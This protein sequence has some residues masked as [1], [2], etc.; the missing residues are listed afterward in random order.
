MPTKMDGP[1]LAAIGIGSLLAFSGFK[2]YSVLQATSNIITGKNP[3]EGQNVSGLTSG[4]TSS[5]PGPTGPV[6]KGGNPQQNMAAGKLLAASYGWTG[7]QWTD[8]VALW[9]GESGWNQFA[10]NASGAYGI[11]Q[12]LPE[13]KYPPAGR[14]ENGSDPI[15]QMRWGLSYIKARYGNPSNTYHIWL[16]RNP[17]WY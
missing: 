11:A 9:N 12:A 4:D 13:S 8:L 7:Q 6:G 2:G 15:V 10:E 17:H 5:N 1:G 14:K 3:N 16:S